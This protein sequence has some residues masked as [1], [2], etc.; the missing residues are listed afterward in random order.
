MLMAK[1]QSH[2][3]QEIKTFRYT[4][5]DVEMHLFIIIV[6][7]HYIYMIRHPYSNDYSDNTE[8][9]ISNKTLFQLKLSWY[10]GDLSGLKRPKCFSVSAPPFWFSSNMA[11]R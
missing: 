6:L 10:F 9:M 2:K 8:F 1:N 5:K 7:G 4:Y 11:K 3:T